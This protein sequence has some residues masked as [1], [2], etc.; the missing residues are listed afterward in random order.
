LSSIPL[1][2]KRLSGTIKSDSDV[3]TGVSV[4]ENG[5]DITAERPLLVDELKD[6]VLEM[7]K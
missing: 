2:I 1:A 6:K 7:I 3:A 5:T 4:S